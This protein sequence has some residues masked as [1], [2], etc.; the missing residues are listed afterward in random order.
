[1]AEIERQTSQTATTDR[2][3]IILGAGG[4]G[5]VVL[6]ILVNAGD[7]RVIG[8][9]DSDVSLAG[10][11]IDGVP[12]LGQPGELPRIRNETGICR[13]IV[14]VGDNG[15]RRAIGDFAENTGFTLINA[16]HPSANIARN[17]SLGRNVVVAAGALVCAH[18]QI[19]DGVI[20]NTGCIVDHEAMIGTATHVCP[21]AR[22]S[23]ERA[24]G[25][26]SRPDRDTRGGGR[27]AD[28]RG[29]PLILE[30]WR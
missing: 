27:V 22:C 9:V 3:C 23:L 18:C 14:A 19:G 4:H 2:R 17:A 10:R 24:S 20:L 26:G 6:D 28:A 12:I 1:M 8:F 15:V 7:A 25:P 30:E 13:A 5:R 21:G 16:I 11:R 29:L